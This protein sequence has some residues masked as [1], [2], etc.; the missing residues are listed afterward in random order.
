MSRIMT[1]MNAT[2]WLISSASIGHP[3]KTL[4]SAKAARAK[5]KTPLI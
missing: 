5:K 4:V 2:S 3:Q 1:W